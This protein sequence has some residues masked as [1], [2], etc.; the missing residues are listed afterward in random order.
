V[1]CRTPAVEER[2]QATIG[3]QDTAPGTGDR[4]RLFGHVELAADLVEPVLGDKESNGAERE[5]EIGQRVADQPSGSE[6]G[7]THGSVVP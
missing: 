7:R 6:T 1:R 4:H 5:H 3:H 2:V